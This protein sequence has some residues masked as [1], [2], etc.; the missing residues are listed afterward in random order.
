VPRALALI[1]TLTILP[2]CARGRD[3]APAS[4]SFPGAPVIVISID[5]LRA[6]HLSTYGYR[7]GSSPAIDRL[8][9]AG[10]V[11]EE[12]FSQ[13]PLTLPS[14]TTLL[15]GRLPL[16]HGV[17]D[18]IGYTVAPEERTLATRLKS[19]GYATGAA[20]SSFVLRHQTG[21]D[22]GFDFF[23]DRFTIAGTGES[24][25]DT[26]RDGRLTADALAA[27]IETHTSQPLFAFLHLYEPHAPYTPP[28]SHAG[29]QPYDGEIAYAD[30]IVGGFLDRLAARGILDR[31]I[32]ALVSDHGEGLGDHGEA[33]HGLLLYREALHVPLIVRLPGG[34]RGGTRIAGAAALV[35]VAPTLLELVGAPTDGLD[36]RSLAAAF[37]SR[38]VADHTV[39]SETMYPRLHFGWSELASVVDGRYHY[40]R[41]P[42]PELYDETADAGERHNLIDSKGSTAAALAGA[43]DRLT[44][45]SAFTPPAAADADVQARLRA[46]GYTT[47]S[48][49]AAASAS[50]LPDPKDKIAD[51][52]ALRRA[53]RLAADGRDRE[54]IELLSPL[55]ARDPAMLDGHELLAKSLTRVGRTREAIDAFGRVLAIEPLKPETHLALARILALERDPARARAHAELAARRDPAAGY[56]MLAELMMDAGRS[57]EAEAFARKSIAADPSRYM[58][59]YVIGVVAQ[60]A[61]RCDEAIAA[62]RAAI[63]AKRSEP[64][65]VVRNLHA[66]LADCLARSGATAE[67]ER[68]FRAEL[69]EVPSSS[70]ARVGLATLYRSQGREAEARTVLGGLIAAQ[71]QPTADAYWTV[72]HAFTVL[73]DAAAAREWTARGRAAFPS[74]PRFR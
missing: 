28:P 43:I 36:G 40:I 25:A 57:D 24:L 46:L 3:A 9:A 61:G 21:I 68:E 44:A 18:N 41:A 69:A 51:Y 15:S 8:A 66:G 60:R 7:G 11:F 45:G 39:Y 23:D 71:P 37:T 65:S 22:R 48:P 32:V 67:A 53:Q 1:L 19:A 42:R 59:H 74:D 64:A 73:G 56:E 31:A 34:V 38:Q 12:A 16:H 63:E 26:Q 47:S 52:E 4:L 30:E 49:G 27:W 29:V 62:F 20:V 70:E 2:G 17:R 58:S 5:T 55:L 54:A 10:L 72:V 14:H 33:E 35:D 13:T 6:D 50:A